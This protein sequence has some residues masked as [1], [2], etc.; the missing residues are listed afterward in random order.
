MQP[1]ATNFHETCNCCVSLRQTQLRDSNFPPM[2][3]F[4]RVRTAPVPQGV[5]K[6]AVAVCEGSYTTA[7]SVKLTAW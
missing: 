4:R 3:S 7:Q 5:S 6:T 1:R 2:V